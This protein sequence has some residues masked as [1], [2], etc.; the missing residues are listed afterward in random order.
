MQVLADL[1]QRHG[2]A[3]G[4]I[5]IE[6]DHLPAADFAELTK[7]LPSSSLEPAQALLPRLRQIKTGQ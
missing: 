3:A 2:L 6:F 5:G 1:L 7:L 4:R